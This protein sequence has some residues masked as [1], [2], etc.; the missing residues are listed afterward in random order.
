[1][2]EHTIAQ[3]AKGWREAKTAE[4]TSRD[5]RLETEGKIIDLVGMNAEGSQTHDA[6]TYK[7]T[8][9]SSMKEN[10][11]RKSGKK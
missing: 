1:M 6:G 8:V 4:N 2:T 7:I 11:M 9:T 10:W 3:L 5:F